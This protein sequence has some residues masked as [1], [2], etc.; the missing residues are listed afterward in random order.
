M[1]P[2]LYF[3]MELAG[4]LPIVLKRKSKAQMAPPP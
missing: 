1:A 2:L 3:E 4:E